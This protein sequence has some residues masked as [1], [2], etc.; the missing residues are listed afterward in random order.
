MYG[1]LFVRARMVRSPEG[2]PKIS[3]GDL[4][5]RQGVLTAV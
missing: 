4:R 1:F 5:R 2:F 3:D